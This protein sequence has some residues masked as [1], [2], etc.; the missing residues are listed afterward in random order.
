MKNDVGLPRTEEKERMETREIFSELTLSN[1]SLKT[2]KCMTAIPT[3]HAVNQ[4]R[5]Y[6]NA[7]YVTQ[8]SL[9]FTTP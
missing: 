4:C 1:N 7:H 3:Q 8:F 5:D 6:K 2:D 9:A